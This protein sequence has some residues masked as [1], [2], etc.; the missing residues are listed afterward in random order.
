MIEILDKIECLLKSNASWSII[1]KVI[2]EEYG[3]KDLSFV[4]RGPFVILER[5]GSHEG[6]AFHVKEN[7]VL[8]AYYIQ[9]GFV[10]LCGSV[11]F[12]GAEGML[13]IETG[14]FSDLFVKD[15]KSPDLA[16]MG[17]AK[18]DSKEDK[19]KKVVYHRA[20]TKGFYAS[21]NI[22]G[23]FKHLEVSGGGTLVNAVVLESAR[24][25]EG[26]AGKIIIPERERISIIA[27]DGDVKVYRRPWIDMLF[28]Q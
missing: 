19:I 15:I 27:D 20:R 28:Y 14:I 26:V 18:S 17:I 1:N 21:G 23:I 2:K 24:I 5:V 22:M 4:K 8:S 13:D 10:R 12:Y 9:E 25:K 11:A 3:V 16:A 7:V 6:F